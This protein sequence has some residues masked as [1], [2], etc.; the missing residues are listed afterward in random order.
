MKYIK[1]RSNLSATVFVPWDCSNNCK[2]CTTKA[3]YK[4]QSSFSL[5]KVIAS[6]KKICKTSVPEIVISGGEPLE[7]IEYLSQI[8]SVIPKTKRIFI[9]TSMITDK[10][11]DNASK[12]ISRFKI[13]GISIS[14]HAPIGSVKDKKLIKFIKGLEYNRTKVR[15]N[16]LVSDKTKIE[17]IVD[18]W[19]KAKVD[20][21]I[22]LRADYRLITNENLKSMDL[23]FQKLYGLYSYVSTS[24]CLVC[25][26]DV[27]SMDFKNEG[28]ICYHRGLENTLIV[29]K[30][31]TILNDIIIK[32]DGSIYVDWTCKNKYVDSI[33]NGLYDD[34]DG[35]GSEDDEDENKKPLKC[36]KSFTNIDTCGISSPSC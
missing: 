36:I 24:G 31:K 13:S 21:D 33:S 1:G 23:V 11:M 7:E 28:K 20:V 32:Q 15:I 8:L 5:K 34:D 16:C 35:D 3:E 10:H 26:T 12:I 17:E 27:F 2:F 4:N 14:R 30:D 6:V 29:I 9:N 19:K 18:S 25:N 22:N